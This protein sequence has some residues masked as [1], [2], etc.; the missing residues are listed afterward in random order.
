[1]WYNTSIERL[2]VI[3]AKDEQYFQAKIQIR[4]YDQE[5]IDYFLKEVDQRDDIFIAKE[6]R[7]KTGIDYYVTSNTAAKA[8]GQKLR[9]RFKGELKVS[10]KLFGINRF[11]S[12]RLWRVT[13]LFRREKR[14]EEN[15]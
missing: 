15:L 7:H 14:E 1:M 9:N 11:T 12:K 5:V 8:V 6:E 10:R 3:Y 13:V 4:P 2:M